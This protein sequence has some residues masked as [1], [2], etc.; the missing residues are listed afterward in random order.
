MVVQI[1]MIL[2]YVEISDAPTMMTRVKRTTETNYD[3][4]NDDTLSRPQIASK[5]PEYTI[6]LYTCIQWPLSLPRVHYQDYTQLLMRI[7]SW[8][9][10]SY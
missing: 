10:R 4:L 8:S 7:N 5:Y 6:W 1:V 9:C 3:T 2:L